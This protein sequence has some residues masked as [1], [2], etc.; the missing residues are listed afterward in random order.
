MTSKAPYVIVT[1]GDARYMP[2]LRELVQSIRRFEDGASFDICIIDAGMTEAQVSEFRS[3]GLTVTAPNWPDCVNMSKI[4]GRTYLKS[5]ICRPFINEIFPGYKTYIWLDG[6]TWV[7]EWSAID[8]LLKG[9]ERSGMA[10]VP[11]VDRAYGKSMRLKW[12]WFLPW[13]PRSFYYSNARIAFSGKLARTLFPYPTINAGVFAVKGDAPHWDHWQNLMGK[14]LVKGKPFTAE[15][16]TMGIMLNLDGYDCER[17]PAWCNWMCEYDALWDA[18]A[19]RFTE[20]Y[21]PHQ[22]LGIVHLTG[23]P[24]M[25]EN[26]SFTKPFQTLRGKIVKT[27]Y[28]YPFYNGDTGEPL[29]PVKAA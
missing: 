23:S 15:Q 20:P 8:L 28:R 25:R 6:D 26:R 19:M 13:K 4:K 12:L 16:L 14:A 7:Q 9:A 17:L 27:S 11:Q 2:L 21:L 1:G 18:K 5:C 10:V 29:Y 22:P 24:E 3:M